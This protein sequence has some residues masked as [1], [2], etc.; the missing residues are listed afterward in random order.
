MSLWTSS[1]DAAGGQ[2]AL[3]P[4]PVRRWSVDEYHAMVCAG[5]LTEDD[6]IELLDGWLVPKMTKKPPHRIAT[7]RVRKALERAAPEG[8]YVDS[9]EP[10][11]LPTSEPEPDGAVIRGDTSDYADRHPGAADLALVVEVADS[12]L[13]ADRTLKKAICAAA[14][15]PV[16]WIVNL[17]ERRLE[18]YGNPTGPAEYPDYHQRRDYVANEEVPLV[19]AGC[20]V[21]RIA[22]DDMLP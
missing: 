18:A 19:V 11:T 1:T 9:Q 4:V 22:V 14:G 20:E 10:V 7:R 16:Y 8:W 2:F 12:G 15:I 5:I 3:P 13:E 6:R 21:A 17:I